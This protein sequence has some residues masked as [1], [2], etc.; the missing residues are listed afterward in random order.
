MRLFELDG[1]DPLV[2]KL[3]AVSDQLHTDLLNGKTDPE[4]TTDEL[5]QYLQKYDIVLDKTD[6]YKMIKK[7]PLNKIISNIQSDKIVF[8]DMGTP[9]APDQEQNNQIV[10]QM[11]NQAAANMQT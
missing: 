4:M 6:L 10:K 2:V 11:A 3:I 9:E 8:K 1:I 5:L 7:P